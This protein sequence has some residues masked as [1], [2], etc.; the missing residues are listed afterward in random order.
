MPD[1]CVLILGRAN[2]PQSAEGL[3]RRKLTRK[4]MTY[5]FMIYLWD[6]GE[7]PDFMKFRFVLQSERIEN[8]AVSIHFLRLYED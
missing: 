6:R 2:R 4:F 3:W 7:V 8:I 5:T 1:N